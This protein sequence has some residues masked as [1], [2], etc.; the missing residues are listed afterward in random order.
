MTRLASSV[1]RASK[2]LLLIPIL[3]G[4]GWADALQESA[5]QTAAAPAADPAAAAA[6][7]DMQM[8]LNLAAE[9]NRTWN[10]DQRFES[11]DPDEYPMTWSV[12]VKQTDSL[13]DPVQAELTFSKN[14]NSSLWRATLVYTWKNGKWIPLSVKW[15]Q[16]G[17]VPAWMYYNI[18]QLVK[19]GKIPPAFLRIAEKAVGK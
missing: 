15:K 16:P 5:E 10:R 3:T 14:F 19:A 8:M 17:D 13:I 11:D 2:L 7:A 12:D 9:L 18:L 4:C 6:A 1:G